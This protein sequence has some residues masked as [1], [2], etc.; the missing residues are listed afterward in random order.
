MHGPRIAATDNFVLYVV[1]RD[2]SEQAH[3]LVWN[4]GSHKLLPSPLPVDAKFFD[5]AVDLRSGQ[6]ATIA[7][8]LG[9]SGRPAK[10]PEDDPC[11]QVTIWDLTGKRVAALRCVG[12]DYPLNEPDERA[13]SLRSGWVTWRSGKNEDK[14]W[15]WR[16]DKRK[17]VRLTP[18]HEEEMSCVTAHNDHLVVGEVCAS[19]PDDLAIER[20]PAAD[21]SGRMGQRG[22]GAS[23]GGVLR[24]QILRSHRSRQRDL[25]AHRQLFPDLAE[26]PV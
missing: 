11:V 13:P 4:L 25:L 26:H 17:L 10:S 21:G 3:L 6:I 2:L 5:A 20:R 18:H 15:T 12:L 22:T 9:G 14:D 8:V 23:G 1:D 24:A 16:I 19:G 7:K